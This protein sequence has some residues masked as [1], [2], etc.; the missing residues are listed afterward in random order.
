[1]TLGF[2]LHTVSFCL[3]FFLLLSQKR[4]RVLHH[5]GEP[6]RR[7][8]VRIRCAVFHLDPCLMSV[9]KTR[10]ETEKGEGFIP[11]FP[12]ADGS[13]GSQASCQCLLMQRLDRESW[14][15][16]PS[17]FSNWWFDNTEFQTWGP[18]DAENYDLLGL[19]LGSRDVHLSQCAAAPLPASFVTC[20]AQ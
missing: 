19:P 15:K 3:L 18:E 6:C 8:K 9:L 2:A 7:E 17:I 14:Y 16:K 13:R 20:L 11:P 1:M 4:K 12:A 10:E 5:L